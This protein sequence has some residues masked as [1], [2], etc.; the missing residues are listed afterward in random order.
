MVESNMLISQMHSHLTS[1]FLRYRSWLVEVV[2]SSCQFT[3]LDPTL[4]RCSTVYRYY[5]KDQW[6]T[7]VIDGIV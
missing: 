6:S 4:F 1:S 7:Q 2:P 5:Q 3:L